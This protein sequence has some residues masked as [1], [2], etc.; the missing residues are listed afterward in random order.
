M[1]VDVLSGIS[2][3][4][5]GLFYSVRWL[6]QTLLRTGVD[7]RLVS[8]VDEHTDSDRPLWSPLDIE[9]YTARGPLLYSSKLRAILRESQADLLH[10][11]GIWLN[12]QWAA[13]QWQKRTGKPVVIS[14]HALCQ[15]EADSIRA[16]G[17]KTPIAIIPNGV[18][19]P[20]LQTSSP[21]SQTH[22]KQLLFLGRIHPK[23]GLAELISG[24]EK[25]ALKGW[26]LIIVGW[27]DGN[28]LAGL[29]QQA[30]D[31]GVGDSISF[32]GPQY[33]EEKEALLRNADAFILPSFS[34]GLPMSVLEAWS[35]GLP[36]V[37]T[38]FCNLPE[39][40]SAGAALRIEPNI[41]SIAQGLA[42]LD[43]MSET[44]LSAMGTH[45]RTLVERSF[46]WDKIA[47]DMKAVYEW[48]LG[49]EKPTCIQEA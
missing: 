34:E 14:P 31:L 46:T 44:D 19:L 12:R 49:G 32:P 45:G 48:C 13:L 35:Y 15:S 9:L 8:H 2:R 42:Q 30:D 27:D 1:K 5:G 21:N 40:F 41:E 4:E 43:S 36:V 11:H 38:D 3:N 47:Q 24:W 26:D 17:L 25:S 22:K 23:K 6:S 10:V 7:I 29:Q 39:G 33:G 18:E 37:M 16:Y 20:S 28:H